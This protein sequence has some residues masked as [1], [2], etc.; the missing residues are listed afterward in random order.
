MSTYFVTAIDTD[1]G[2]TVVTGLLGRY[3]KQSGQ[4]VITMK[5]SQTGCENLS[6]DIAVHRQLMGMELMEDDINGL[7]C[8]YLFRFPASPHLAAAMEN[9]H[10]SEDEL[11]KAIECIQGK[12][13]NVL[14]EGVG[15][16]MVPI[17]EE[18]L[19]ADF[20][21]KHNFPVIVVTSGRLGSINHTLLTLEVLKA[22][23]IPVYGIIYN[24]YPITEVQITADSAKLLR[25]YLQSYYPHALWGEVPMVHN[26]S[27][28]E[29]QLELPGWFE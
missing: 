20:I 22:R 23:N 5:L 7:T 10:I 24:H 28:E 12:Y 11:V 14:V 4:D 18:L 15:G 9:V 21:Q 19:V 27:A 29:L 17:N 16:L 3:L 25:R 6:D 8:P 2:K 13:A 1:A 26:Y